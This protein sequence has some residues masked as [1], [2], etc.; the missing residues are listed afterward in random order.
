M[1]LLSLLACPPVNVTLVLPRR[2]RVP[3]TQRIPAKFTNSS[4]INEAP[5]LTTIRVARSRA[6]PLSGDPRYTVCAGIFYIPFKRILHDAVSE[7]ISRIFLVCQIG[8]LNYMI[9]A[10]VDEL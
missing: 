6:R 2:Q 1:P 4:Q 7:S 9:K 10:L 5:K 3:N 8:I